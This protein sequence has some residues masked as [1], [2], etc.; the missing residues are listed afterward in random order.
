ME[1][2]RS[3]GN[4]LPG[5]VSQVQGDALRPEQF[6]RQGLQPGHPRRSTVPVKDAGEVHIAEDGGQV[7]HYARFFRGSEP[8]PVEG[9]LDLEEQ[10]VLLL[11]LTAGSWHR[12]VASLLRA[13]E[14]APLSSL[15]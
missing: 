4:V 6:L 15:A 14:T 9:A 5:A 8:V 10:G 11:L 12:R 13:M 1:L 3:K 7:L 2:E